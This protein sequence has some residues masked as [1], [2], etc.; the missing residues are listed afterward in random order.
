[1]GDVVVRSDLQAGLEARCDRLLTESFQRLPPTDRAPA[2]DINATVKQSTSVVTFTRGLSAMAL[3]LALLAGNAAVCAG[4]AA[5]PEARMACCAE[6]AECPMH[7]S[8]SSDSHSR[9]VIS[10]AQADRCCASS[11]PNTSGP[12]TPTFA[13]TFS[14]AVLSAAIVLPVETPSLV[15]SEAWRSFRPLRASPVQKHVLLSVFLV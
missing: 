14:P 8:D 10:Q 6:G 7:K 12:S 13:V 9:R 4:W 11:E 3:T 5:T 1:L 15:L 2:F